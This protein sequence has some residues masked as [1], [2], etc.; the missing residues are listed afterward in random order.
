MPSDLFVGPERDR[1]LDRTVTGSSGP[2]VPVL[3]IFLRKTGED[4]G[5]KTGSGPV[6]DQTETVGV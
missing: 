3:P 2:T 1:E 4:C 5:P 6:Q